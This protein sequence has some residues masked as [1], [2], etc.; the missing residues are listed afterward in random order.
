VVVG[1][2]LAALYDPVWLAGIHNRAD[3]M[4]GLGAFGLLLFW[5]APSWFVVILISMLVKK[6][7]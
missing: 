2:L 4:V 1:I 3:F 7:H 6:W 5:K